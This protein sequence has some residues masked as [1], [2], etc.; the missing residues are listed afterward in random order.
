LTKVSKRTGWLTEQQLHSHTGRKAGV[1]N[2]SIGTEIER[3]RSTEKRAVGEKQRG[4]QPTLIFQNFLDVDGTEANQILTPL[5][6]V[7]L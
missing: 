1:Q 7:T 3:K 6:V 5:L 2:R 4:Y